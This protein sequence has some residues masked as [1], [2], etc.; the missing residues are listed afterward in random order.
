MKKK[1]HTPFLLILVL[2]FSFSAFAQENESSKYRIGITNGAFTPEIRFASDFNPSVAEMFN[3]KYFCLIQFYAIPTD[4]Q[5]KLWEGQGLYLTDYLP[6]NTYF[7]VV[8]RG[9]LWPALTI[10]CEPFFRL[11]NA[12]KWKQ[13]CLLPVFLTMH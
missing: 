3:G 10:L 4:E 2:I 6:V 1:S 7:A 13:N 5:R 9:F 12:S 8:E 11:I